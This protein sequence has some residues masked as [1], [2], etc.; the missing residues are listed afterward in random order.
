MREVLSAE[1][2]TYLFI[3]CITP[4]PNNLTCLYLGASKG[5]G[6]VHRFLSA[7]VLSLFIKSVI[8]GFVNLGLAEAVPS[9]PGWLMWIG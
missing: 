7:S 9:A 3:M 8:C 2:L 4:G 6:G 1:L 5:V